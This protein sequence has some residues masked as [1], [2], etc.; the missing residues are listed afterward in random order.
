MIQVVIFRKSCLSNSYSCLSDLYLLVLS[1][2][3]RHRATRESEV[4]ENGGEEIAGKEDFGKSY[5]DF[6]LA[7]L[8]LFKNP[9]YV[10]GSLA[11]CTEAMVVSGFTTFLP[12]IIENEFQQTAGTAAIVAGQLCCLLLTRL[13][14]NSSMLIV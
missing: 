1:G 6:P 9:T 4:P 5:K 3:A 8:T 7:L 13:E 2:T 14:H 10:F 11:S 12:K